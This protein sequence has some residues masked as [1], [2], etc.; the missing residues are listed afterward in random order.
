MIDKI[1]ELLT[2]LKEVHE[3]LYDLSTKK[4]EAIIASDAERVNG[5][6]KQEWVLLSE[7]GDLEKAREEII[8]SEFAEWQKNGR[9]FTMQ[10]LIEVTP[11]DMKPQ[12]KSLAAGFSELVEKQKRINHENQSLIN[13]HLEY[14]DYVVNTVLKEPQISNIYGTSGAVAESEI[15]NRGIYDSQA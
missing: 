11:P 5:I 10:D 8:D 6:V 15:T 3:K 12:M 1:M 7:A 14:M 13:L 9:Q 4:Q 2:E